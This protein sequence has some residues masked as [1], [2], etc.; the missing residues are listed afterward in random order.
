MSTERHLT[1]LGGLYIALG[2]LNVLIA[3]VTFASMVA[4]GLLSGDAREVTQAVTSDVRAAVASIN[5]LV[6]VLA[7]IGGI[8]LLKRKSWSWSLVYIMSCMSLLSVPIGTALGVYALW[9]L[10]RPETEQSLG[11][12]TNVSLMRRTIKITLALSLVL[13]IASF[14]ACYLGE[15]AV[16]GELSKLSPAELELRQFDMVYMRW[17]LPGVLMFLW[18]TIL[19][20]V[21]ILSWLVERRRRVR[22]NADALAER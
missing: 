17:A 6:A 19:A 8:G 4:A 2:A 5:L 22:H 21:T 16:Q 3:L 15:H 11:V 1:T 10:M 13:I 12:G 9:V 14:P 18:G 20:I 7:F